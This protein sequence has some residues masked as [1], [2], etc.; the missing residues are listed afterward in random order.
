MALCAACRKIS[1]SA[2][3]CELSNVPSWW[4]KLNSRS[5]PRG[6]VHHN[7]ARQLRVSVEAGC[8]LCLLIRDSLFQFNGR[9]DSYADGEEQGSRTKTQIGSDLERYL[10]DSPI[11]LRP[12]FDPL[13][14]AFPQDGV[15]NAPYVR[16][17][18]V[19]VP[20]HKDILV[21]QVRLFA[22]RGTT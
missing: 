2:L 18:K 22:L 5:K 9:Q 11:Y 19:F 15:L 16:G 10:I 3:V 8:P 21:G 6:M 1:V 7:D 13:K 20:L 14:C 4:E 17:F 12:N